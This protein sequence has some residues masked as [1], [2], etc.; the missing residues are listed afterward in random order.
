MQT[1]MPTLR[2][3]PSGMIRAGYFS[4]QRIILRTFSRQRS[5]AQLV[6][7]SP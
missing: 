3:F 4:S 1:A 7:V 2:I 6:F 5:K